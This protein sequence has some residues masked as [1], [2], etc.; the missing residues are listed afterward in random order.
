MVN[1]TIQL[2]EIAVAVVRKDI[3]NVHLSVYPPTGSVRIAAPSR[4]RL[5]TIRVFALSKLSWIKK[6]QRRLR[7]Q[8][9]ESPREYLERESQYVWGKRYLL[10]LAIGAREPSIELTH[11]HFVL[12]LGRGVSP[13]SA[14][15]VVEKW[16]RNQV[17]KAVPALLGKWQP[18]LGVTV[19][20]VFVRRMKTKWGSCSRNTR[21]IR[22]NTDLAKK[23]PQCLEYIVVHELIHLLEPTHNARFVAL[24]D[25]AMPRW[26]FHREQLNRL[27]VRHEAW[28]Y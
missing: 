3:R 8:P 28:S 2:G 26:R 12:R 1:H 19:D 25:R 15:A 23:P 9:R 6:Q 18:R 20:G 5:D 17:R 14:Q 21:T 13:E 24:M 4:M 11:R 7:D 16:Y 10:A 27:P 22:L